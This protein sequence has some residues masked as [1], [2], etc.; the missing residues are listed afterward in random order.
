MQ[1]A[2]QRKENSYK[3]DKGIIDFHLNSLEVED[4]STGYII[5]RNIGVNESSDICRRKAQGARNREKGYNKKA[6]RLHRI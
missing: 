1:Q 3:H 6:V 5:E 2:I 4:S